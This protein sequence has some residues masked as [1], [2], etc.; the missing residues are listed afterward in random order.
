MEAQDVVLSSKVQDAEAELIRD[1]KACLPE[2][3]K[4][5]YQRHY[6]QMYVYIFCRLND[7][8]SAEDLASQVFLE[9]FRGI[10]SFTYRGVPFSA[11]LYKI[12]HNLC[13][14]FVRRRRVVLQPLNEADESNAGS[15]DDWEAINNHAALAAALP[16]LTLEQQQV[17]VLRFVKDMPLANVAAALGKSE[18]AVKALQHRALASLRR[19]LRG[20]GG[21]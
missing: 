20:E 10:R 11:W 4:E 1:A 8:A 17:V 5:I 14:D 2:A 21:S 15:H 16:R 3:W 12:A 18:E 13:I 19:Y 6:K 9:A 7:R